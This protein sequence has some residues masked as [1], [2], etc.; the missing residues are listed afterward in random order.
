[1]CFVERLL[2]FLPF[3]PQLLKEGLCFDP[4]FWNLLTLRTHCLEL[5]SDKAGKAALSE[6]PEEEQV[7]EEWWT[8]SDLSAP[9]ACGPK[10]G[11]ARPHPEAG[12]ASDASAGRE[13]EVEEGEASPE[14][15]PDSPVKRRWWSRRRRRRGRR[16]HGS[17]DADS[18]DDPEFKY[19]IQP[20][21]TDGRSKYSLRRHPASA[22]EGGLKQPANRQREYLARRDRKSTRLNSS[23]L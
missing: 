5:M 20:T 1:M 16:R 4:E 17:D 18:G 8:P 6:M 11:A 9:Q 19:A 15:T 22:Q 12:P 21:Y 13:E 2:T 3:P 10:P 23:H 7:E 14:P